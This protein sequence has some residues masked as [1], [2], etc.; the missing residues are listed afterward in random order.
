LLI[1]KKHFNP[2]RI[3]STANYMLRVLY[4]INLDRW[5][6]PV[7]S[8]LR[9]LTLRNPQ[10]NFYSF[11]KPTC[12]EDTTLGKL[13][14][15]QKHIHKILPID[16]V[17]KSFDI[18]H[19]ASATT[20]NLTASAIAKMRSFG[21]CVHIFTA[22]IQPHK[23][24][25]YYKQYVMSV[26]RADVLAAVSY[27]VAD[28]IQAQFGRKVDAVIP[29]GVDLNFFSPETTQPVNYEKLGIRQPFV[30]FVGILTP[31]KRPDIFMQ[32]ASL[33][34]EFDFVMVGGFYNDPEGE[35]YKKAALEYS[36]VK[37]LGALPRTEVRNLMADALALVF[38]SE[39]EGLPLTILEAS[40]MGL[41]I[42]SQPKSAMPEAV[43]EDVTGWMFS[44]EEWSIWAEKLKE[45]ANWSQ[46]TRNNFSQK[47]RQFVSKHYSWELVARQYANLYAKVSAN[48]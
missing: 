45:I 19:H 43:I 21:K 28:D 44:D 14:W 26:R 7:S 38:P 10:I 15:S 5:K 13:L 17:K 16:L 36:N 12:E 8:S 20:S 6:F 2:D 30:L 32:I 46:M 27:A 35:K 29:S 40:A 25:R 4:P 33:L 23:E 11:S 42:L 37:L 47:A 39:L 1:L 9:E 24:D 34:P 41:P 48:N 18:V 3:R 31:R 22:P